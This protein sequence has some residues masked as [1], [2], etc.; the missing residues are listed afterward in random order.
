MFLFFY[1]LLEKLSHDDIVKLVEIYEINKLDIK[2]IDKFINNSINNELE[3]KD[4]LNAIN[5]LDMPIN[6]LDMPIN[7][8]DID[9]FN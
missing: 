8:L 2:R 4:D 6:N 1:D 5:N 3:L 9:D 7:N